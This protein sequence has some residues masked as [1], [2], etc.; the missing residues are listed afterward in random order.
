MAY[1][2]ALVDPLASHILTVAK[3][4][5]FGDAYARINR[6]GSV[7]RRG[8]TE[9]I[10]DGLMTAERW[11]VSTH[12]PLNGRSQP[13]LRGD[14]GAES[15]PTGVDTGGRCHHR[16]ARIGTGIRH[17]PIPSNETAQVET[18]RHQR[19]REGD[20]FPRGRATV[21][22]DAGDQLF[23]ARRSPGCSPTGRR[24]DASPTDRR[25]DHRMFPRTACRQRIRSR[26]FDGNSA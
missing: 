6:S 12:G 14:S 21:T 1:G 3:G 10:P 11:Q 2:P 25:E 4:G 20:Q 8:G 18:S 13:G 15:S 5:T 26:Q 19:P 16:S 22:L 17:L 23:V 7:D 9:V 24:R